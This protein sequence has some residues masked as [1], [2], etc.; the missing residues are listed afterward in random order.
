MKKKRIL[1]KELGDTIKSIEKVHKKQIKSMEEMNK[2]VE[3]TIHNNKIKD[4]PLSAN[5]DYLNK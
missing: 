4:F 3:E 1:L 5:G 2:Q